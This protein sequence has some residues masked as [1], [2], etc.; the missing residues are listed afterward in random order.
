MSDNEKKLTAYERWELPHL[1]SAANPKQSSQ[2][3]AIKPDDA[4]EISEEIDEDSLVYEPLTAQQLEEIR[5]AAYE[6]GYAQGHEE[7]IKAGH[8]EGSLKG[9]EEGFQ[10]GLE[11]G[12]A[13]GT[14]K[15]LQEGI[16][17]AESRLG[18]VEQL[19]SSV[20]NEFEHPLESSRDQ[21]EHLLQAAT[22]R[23]GEHL[24]KRELGESS[25]ALLTSELEK[26]LNTLG[27]QEG[28]A[29]LRVHPDNLEAAQA[30]ALDQRLTLKIKPDSSLMEGGFV[31]DSH[32]FYVDGTIES[33]LSD[34]L[35]SLDPSE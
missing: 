32:A 22:K 5:S 4:V 33:R 15:A 30:L 25:D 8:E 29:V 13:E 20:L 3:L 19:L 17:L 12:I 16:A 14:E 34:V 6:E 9:H 11:Q 28:R 10:Q 7:G 26:V 2:A 31:L 1:E 24:T 23:I 35:K 18:S 27:E 21:L